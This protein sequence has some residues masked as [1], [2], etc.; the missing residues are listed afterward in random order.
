MLKIHPKTWNLELSIGFNKFNIFPFHK[1]N[2][3]KEPEIV[4]RYGV[5]KCPKIIVL[6]EGRYF[7]YNGYEDNNNLEDLIKDA[8]K[9]SSS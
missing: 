1:I 5:K 4:Y 7:S 2:S 6:T 8:R 3:E 9:Y